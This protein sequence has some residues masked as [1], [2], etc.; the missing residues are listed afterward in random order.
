MGCSVFSDHDGFL[1]G[2]SVVDV[3]EFFDGVNAFSAHPGVLVVE[4][5]AVDI[6]ANPIN[7]FVSGVVAGDGVGRGGVRAPDHG[8]IG[9]EFTHFLGNES[10]FFDV[11]LG[12]SVVF[13]PRSVHFAGK[14]QEDGGFGLSHFFGESCQIGIVHY[15][16]E[17]V[18]WL[19]GDVDNFS[20]LAEFGDP[21]RGEPATIS[22][23]VEV[24]GMGFTDY[25]FERP[26]EP[27]DFAS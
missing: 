19:E 17:T 24:R 12:V 2:V 7:I 9:G 15:Q 13:D 1:F 21:I 22:H 25:R 3:V 11:L 27:P 5:D 18:V 8:N 20:V 23:V 6:D 16:V 14:S 26:G 4:R 10:K